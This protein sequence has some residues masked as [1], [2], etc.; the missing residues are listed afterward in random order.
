MHANRDEMPTVYDDN[1]RRPDGKRRAIALSKSLLAIVAWLAIWQLVAFALAN[2]WLLSGP[3]ETLV[4]WGEFALTT[5]F[6]QTIACSLGRIALGFLVAFVIGTVL[7]YLAAK[8]PALRTFLR[9]A[10]LAIK[11]APVVCV[12]AL[13][14]VAFG[15]NATTSIVVGLVVFPQFYHAI[16]EAALAHENEVNKALDVFGIPTIRRAL[17]VDLVAFGASLRA[18]TATAVGL[19]WKSG[20]AA[21]IIGLPALSIGSGVYLAKI[22]LDSASIIAWTTTVILLC[23]LSEKLLMALVD[24]GMRLPEHWLA[25]RT[26]RACGRGVS[27]TAEDRQAADGASGISVHEVIRTFPDG[28]GAEQLRYDDI[29][30][31]PGGRLCVMAPSGSG[32]STLLRMIAG[33][34]RPTSGTIEFTDS[35]SLTSPAKSTNPVISLVLQDC[36][37]V[38][39]ATAL[40]N[41]ALVAEKPDEVCRGSRFLHEL[42]SAEDL[43]K[44]ARELSGGTRRRAE[45]CRALAHPSSLVILDEPFAGLD[46]VTKKRCMRLIDEELVGRTLVI[47]T[48]EE[49]DA[50]AL[51]CN[52]VKL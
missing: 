46:A 34:D 38:E 29:E 4:A 13:L 50:A 21:E 40:E 20:V 37:L 30:I 19:A 45:I 32:K 2:P 27:V 23:W 22:S 18:A 16:M 9:P 47:A 14:L 28:D 15:S 11:S 51:G 7:G 1:A 10:V 43:I 44:P 24:A 26:Q 49:E 42:I 8:L 39:W 35:A 48:H 6:W 33:I 3:L 36:S 52:I 17:C 31:A 41:V 5:E 12:I 25:S